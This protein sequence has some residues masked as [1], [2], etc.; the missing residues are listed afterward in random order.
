MSV[1]WRHPQVTKSGGAGDSAASPGT[2]NSQQQARFRSA[3]S[4]NPDAYEAYLRGRYYLSNQFTMAQ[5]L[6]MAKSY[7]EESIRKDP[8]FALAY[9]G[10]ADSYVYLAI[11]RQ[12]S[13]EGAYRPAKEALRKALELDDS[14]GEAHDTLGVLSWRSELN[15]KAAEQ[16]FNRAIA[17]A[18][19][20]SCAHEDRAVYLS[21]VGRRAEALAEIAKSSELDPGPSSAMAESGAYY[22][23]RITK[24]WL[25]QAAGEWFLIRM[26][27]LNTILSASAMKVQENYWK[28]FLSIRRQLRYRMAITMPPLRSR[29]RLQRS[30]EKL[31]RRK[32]FMTSSENRKVAMFR[33][34]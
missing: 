5:P 30:A 4:V 26:N 27:G 28:R 22:Q 9:S 6:N 17:L 18:P 15:W 14:I 7:F 11:F 29:T 2:V 3:G 33:R 12:L 34:I 23:L 13:P 32:S 21:F 20:Y 10:L 25:K 31:K 1:I 19:S 8:G 16:E 24:V